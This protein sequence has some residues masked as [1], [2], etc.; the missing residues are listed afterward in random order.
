LKLILNKG[1]KLREGIKSISFSF[2]KVNPCVFGKGV[3]KG[4]VIVIAIVGHK[5][6]RTPQITMNNFKGFGVNRGRERCMLPVRLT[7]TTEGT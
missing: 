5:W 2:K 6:S 4:D 7:H 1:K 3:Y